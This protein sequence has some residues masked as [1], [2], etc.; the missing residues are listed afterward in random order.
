[1]SNTLKAFHDLLLAEKPEGAEH[2]EAQCPVCTPDAGTEHDSNQGEPVSDTTY[3][4]ADLSARVDAA[5][6][7]AT[8]PLIEKIGSFESAEGVA[9][10]E[11][12]I[13]A[14]KAEGEE[15]VAELQSE[16]DTKTL[17]LETVKKAHDELVALLEET[18]KAEKEAAELEARKTERV[19]QVK[20]E[21]SFPED[22]V[23]DE[24]CDRLAAMSDEDFE[25]NLAAWKALA[26]AT[27]D[28]DTDDPPA[29]TGLKAAR[30]GDAAGDAPK[31][32][33]S[34]LG[35]LAGVRRA[36]AQTV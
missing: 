25:T 34:A 27:A 16:L 9:E 29:D 24:F 7:E 8:K 3:T 23:N 35:T 14:A 30:D 31:S 36:K 6:A 15:K 32:N 11:A 17:E 21:V 20:A 26:P 1:M 2:D 13:A 18:E 12:A 4:E 10:I 19:E 5:V 33:L 28:A 22:Y